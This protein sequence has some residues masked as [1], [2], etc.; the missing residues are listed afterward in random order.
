MERK[1]Y[2]CRSHETRECICVSFDYFDTSGTNSLRRAVIAI[3]LGTTPSKTCV[4]PPHFYSVVALVNFKNYNLR[5]DTRFGGCSNQNTKFDDFIR[6][7]EMKDL[8]ISLF[9]RVNDFPQ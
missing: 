4:L 9:Y 8:F 6:A 5:E 3:S 7:A 1:S 2:L